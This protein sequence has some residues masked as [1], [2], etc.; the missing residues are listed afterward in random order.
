MPTSCLEPLCGERTNGGSASLLQGQEEAARRAKSRR[1]LWL[2]EISSAEATNNRQGV[3]G[4][5]EQRERYHATTRANA[6][7]NRWLMRLVSLKR[8]SG[9]CW[10]CRP[11]Q[12]RRTIE[13]EFYNFGM[14]LVGGAANHQELVVLG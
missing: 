1:S 10:S 6:H 3:Q 5:V 9:A 2:P 8:L 13:Q 12:T 4:Q 7:G 11:R 14:V